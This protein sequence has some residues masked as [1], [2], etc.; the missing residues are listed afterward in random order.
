M[1]ILQAGKGFG[2]ECALC[3]ILAM[4]NDLPLLRNLFLSAVCGIPGPIANIYILTNLI[5]YDL[6][7]L[8]TGSKERATL[9]S[10]VFF[11]T[12]LVLIR[13][14]MQLPQPADKAS[15]F[16]AGNLSRPQPGS[17]WGAT[18]EVLCST[19]AGGISADGTGAVLGAEATDFIAV[20]LPGGCWGER[21]RLLG[22]G[23]RSKSDGLLLRRRA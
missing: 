16:P 7:Y 17:F 23:P 1:S 5:V 8:L 3:G 18:G 21:K 6:S 2:Y 20:G 19:G 22:R 15:P 9:G 4:A 10:A 14:G 13:S 12:N 11:I